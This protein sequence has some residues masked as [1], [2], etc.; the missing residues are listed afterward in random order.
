M[1]DP[2]FKFD[3]K[4]G[5]FVPYLAERW[6]QLDD[7]NIRIHLKKGVKFHNGEQLD[8]EGVVKVIDLAI[9][10]GGGA[11]KKWLSRYFVEWKTSGK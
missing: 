5:N 3:D 8:A 10:E 6:E 2:L 7:L 1:Y 9:K 4:N 11:T